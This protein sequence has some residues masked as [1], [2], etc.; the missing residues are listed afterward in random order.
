MRTRSQHS[1]DGASRLRCVNG[2]PVSVVA[3]IEVPFRFAKDIQITAD[4]GV[5]LNGVIHF[6][7]NVEKRITRNDG[8]VDI[9]KGNE[10]T[11]DPDHVEIQALR[12]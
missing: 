3:E 12:V 11:Y 5:L 7:G 1:I 6:K 10:M 4:T 2:L 9:I 8:N